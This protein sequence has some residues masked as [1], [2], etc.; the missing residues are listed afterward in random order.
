MQ[1]KSKA[2]SGKLACDGFR[3]CLTGKFK[4]TSDRGNIKKIIEDLGGK[5]TG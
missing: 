1:K 4:C 5:V 3:Y 2:G